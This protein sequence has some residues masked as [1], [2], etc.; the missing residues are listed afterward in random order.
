[1]SDMERIDR[2]EGPFEVASRLGAEFGVNPQYFD[3]AAHWAHV[4][5]QILRDSGELSRASEKGL[6]LTKRAALETNPEVALDENGKP[7]YQTEY[8]AQRTLYE[9]AGRNGAKVRSALE[10]D[11]LRVIPHFDRRDEVIDTLMN[12]ME[13]RTYPF[14]SSR[15]ELPQVDGNMP[16]TLERG[17]V[18]EALYWFISC[19]FMRGQI[20]SVTAIRGLSK[21]YDK[22]PDMFNPHLSRMLSETEIE[23]RL[24][25]HGLGS[26]SKVNA[27][28]WQKNSQ[29]LIDYCDA[30]PRNLF[31]GTTDYEVLKQR[32][33]RRGSKGFLGFQEK[34]TS[35]LTY[36]LMSAGLVEY[37]HH[38]LPVDLHVTRVSASNGVVTFENLPPNGN[39]V[40]QQTFDTLRKMYEDYSH[41]HGVSQL[42]LCDALW[43]FGTAMCGDAVGNHMNEPNGRDNRDGR[44]TLLVQEAITFDRTQTARWIRSCG[45]CVL[46]NTCTTLYPA[47][48]WYLHGKLLPYERLSP[49]KEDGGLFP[50]HDVTYV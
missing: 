49:P 4:W 13:Q 42:A 6:L 5:L 22:H 21:L 33:M 48:H 34:M 2:P 46:R 24:R 27:M 20:G 40:S 41:S 32:I 17:G 30:D 35:M 1:M 14:N 37:H 16:E 38:P 9:L 15:T 12:A 25:D 29:R 26:G 10:G 43:A 8:L 50:L 3:H 23:K 45:S 47:K 31:E 36:W 39:I 44:R 19:Y 7:S 18:D 28:I 11:G